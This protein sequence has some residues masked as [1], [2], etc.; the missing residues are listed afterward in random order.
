MK[1]AGVSGV[2]YRFETSNS[3]L[4]KKIHPVGK[5][6][7][8]QFEHLKFMK[9]LGF[10]IATGSIIGLPEQT[11][12]DLADDILMMKKWAN[13][14]SMGPFVACTNTPFSDSENG[15]VELNLRMIAILRLIMKSIRIPV[16]T[17]LETLGGDSGRKRALQAGANALMLNLTPEKYRSLYEIYPDKFYQ[18]DS[19]WE[20][21]GL[22]KAEESYQMLEERM[23]DE[24]INNN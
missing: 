8:T 23:E 22:F 24:L 1:D 2:L 11:I 6:F 12:S 13:M 18:K 3:E 15:N 20:K 9:E 21:Y 17:A 5:S 4:F 14:V 16:V 10:F 7:Q 19:I